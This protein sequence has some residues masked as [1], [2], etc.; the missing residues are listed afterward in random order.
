MNRCTINCTSEC[1]EVCTS[2]CACNHMPFP[3]RPGVL[4]KKLK[5]RNFSLKIFINTH[6]LWGCKTV[7]I[8]LCTVYAELISENENQH[9][10]KSNNLPNVLS[11]VTRYLVRRGDLESLPLNLTLL[12]ISLSTSLRLL[13]TLL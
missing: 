2:V 13:Y 4:L 12:L 7:Y 11:F 9:R 5:R 3:G 8:L 6:Y 10:D 1:C